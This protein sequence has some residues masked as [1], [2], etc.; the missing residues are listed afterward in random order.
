VISL[1][2]RGTA[3]GGHS[4]SA[5]TIIA[6]PLSIASPLPYLFAEERH[7]DR[8]A[9]EALF[10]TFN[11]DLGF[12]ERTVLGVTQAAGARV[13]VVGDARMSDPDPRAARNAGTRYVH[14][15]AATP[16]GAAFHPKVTVIAGPERAMVAIGSGNL[17]PGGWHLNKETWTVATADRERCPVMVMQ[18]AEWLRG[19]HHVCAITPQ[20]VQGIQRTAALLEQL[21][22]TS[23]LTD[24]GHQ[25]VH[26]SAR[27][28]LDQLPGGRAD[29]LLIYAPF[30]DEN[31]EAIRCLIERLAPARVNLAVQS[32]HRTVIQP[33]AV[34]HVLDGLD[35]RF[36][37]VEDTSKEYRHGKLIEAVD[38]DGNRWTL[39]GSPNLSAHALLRSA[40]DGGNI[41]V[42]LVSRPRSSLF[43]GGQPITLSDVPAVRIGD[44]AANRPVVGVL[45]LAAVRT[46][47]GLQVVF[48]K[49]PAVAVQI[50]SSVH[51]NF[52][53]WTDVG[54]VPSGVADYTFTDVDLPG[55]TRVRA[56]WDAGADAVRGS[57]VFV[58][59][60]DLVL[61][62]PGE[63]TPH[64][65]SAPPDPIQL[66]TDPRLLEMWMSAVGQLAA[67]RTAVAL[68]RATGPAA[69]RGE[70]AAAQHGAGLRIDTDEERW[71]S[72]ADDAQAR[73]GSAMFHF[74]LG[75]FPGLRGLAAAVGGGLV[76][77][78]DRVIDERKPG[79][80][81]DEPDTVNDDVDPS[82]SAND[83]AEG[84]GEVDG[85]ADTSGDDAA[86]E[87]TNG[88][89]SGQ[90]AVSDLI[91]T[92][93]EKRRIQRDLEQLVTHVA[94]NLPAIDRLA[95]INLVLCA[96]Q[97]HVWEDPLGDEGWMRILAAAL[98]SLDLGDIPERI[99]RQAA[100][101][102]AVA[103]YL[104][105]E[106]RPTT[107]RTAEVLLY[108][109]AASHTAHLYVEA[110]PQLVADYAAPF[111]NK[112]GYPIDPDAVMHVISMIVQGDPLAEAADLL[113]DRHPSWQIHKH[114]DTLLHIDGD[115]RVP[116]LPA[117]E[118][119]DAIVGVDR[120]GVWAT[121]RSAAWT[122][123]TRHDDTLI[124]VDRQKGR[125]MWWHYRL[126]NLISPSGIAHDQDLANRVRISHG[127]LNQAFPGAQKALLTIGFD[128]TAEPPSCFPPTSP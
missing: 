35:V 25:L 73:L 125:F 64:K 89:L 7:G 53:Q 5:E 94:P 101:V 49:P 28:L 65:R 40:A 23:T 9:R 31:A 85:A 124:R 16:S 33:D 75:G 12:F 110:D 62:R 59:D 57:V 50:L 54:T 114:N 82:A 95:I 127:S 45:L 60:P 77:P 119:L 6:E 109:K 98:G 61:E 72:Y 120:I 67:A 55:G 91:R 97:S 18:L 81:E 100:S 88:I 17:S 112:N 44:S 83:Q 10:C 56:A 34:A 19:L 15:L 3:P 121:G 22:A 96:V 86:S 11:A 36:K 27:P 47:G 52:D 2:D 118:A 20:A 37:V 48:A 71:L 107:G 46:G 122:V 99:C 8:Q 104:M 115:F 128:P 103:I 26:T 42:G 63:S 93:R 78:T 51:A 13:T 80:D 4:G 79:L 117:A 38:L 84:G 14:G 30:H 32:D 123:V 90:L 70:A 39:T 74:A 1:P 43:P 108:E 68:P 106:Y 111:T 76:E 58:I 21:A 24:T 87:D 92:V 105:H 113:E 126:S 66:I 29:H 69:P 116:F 41:E 102:A